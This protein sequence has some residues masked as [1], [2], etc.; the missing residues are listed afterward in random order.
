[1]KKRKTRS[2]KENERIWKEW[3]NFF[4]KPLRKQAE[5]K[6][7]SKFFNIFRSLQI[8]IALEDALEQMPKYAKYLKDI[9][10]KK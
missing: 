4:S 1:M 5:D 8:N 3:T 7:Y 2:W 6:Q 10:T 9:L